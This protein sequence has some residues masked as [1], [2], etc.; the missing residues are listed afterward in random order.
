MTDTEVDH[1]SA[2]IA[3]NPVAAAMERYMWA[4][5]R[6]DSSHGGASEAAAAEKAQEALIAE[7]EKAATRTTVRVDRLISGNVAV[8]VRMED[9][10]HSSTGYAK[11]IVD[12]D[13]QAEHLVQIARADAE[14]LLRSAKSALEETE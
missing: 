13:A 6:W 11:G 4:V 14:A 3:D 1:L 2:L 8:T 7:L 12:T 10:G 5:R 9:G